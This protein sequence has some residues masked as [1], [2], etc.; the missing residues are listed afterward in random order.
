MHLMI[1]TFSWKCSN[2][3]LAIWDS[4]WK[5]FWVHWLKGF[6]WPIWSSF[7]TS[8]ICLECQWTEV[9]AAIFF[10]IWWCTVL[11]PI[12]PKQSE[13]NFGRNQFLKRKQFLHATFRK[14]ADFRIWSWNLDL[15]IQI[16]T[17]W[18]H[19]LPSF[20]GPML[21]RKRMQT[22]RV[23]R[24]HLTKCTELTQRECQNLWLKCDEKI[25]FKTLR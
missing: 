18:G 23:N 7:A 14:F 9:R 17:V 25:N 2:M 24:L 22:S 6:R 15:G 19:G 8:S 4:D 13:P 5:Q 3:D 12:F 20:Y 10:E 21:F 1:C 16:E 11:K